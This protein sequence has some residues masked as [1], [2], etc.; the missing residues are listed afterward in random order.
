M[1]ATESECPLGDI[2]R[3]DYGNDFL[4]EAISMRRRLSCSDNDTGVESQSATFSI[5][6]LP[7]RQEITA[8][9]DIAATDFKWMD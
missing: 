7:R 9:P 8:S 4:R 3:N 2:A 1:N 6:E 5:C